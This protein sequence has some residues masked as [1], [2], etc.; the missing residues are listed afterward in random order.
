MDAA[1]VLTPDDIMAGARVKGPVLIY[2]DDQYYMGGV[3]AEKLR[4]QGLDVTLATPGYEVSTWTLFT[5]EQFKVQTKLLKMGVK[6]V[7]THKLNAW[8]GDHAELSSI[9]TGDPLR[10]EAATLVTVTSRLSNDSLFRELKADAGGLAKAGIKTLRAIGD[11][12]VPGAIVHA[13]YSGH[14]AAREHGEN[15]DPDAFPYKREL[16]FVK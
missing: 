1:N 16:V 15:I 3:L 8:R 13:V 7:L 5:D 11:C 14:K 9:Y 10:V 12:D 2:D 6:L 4:A